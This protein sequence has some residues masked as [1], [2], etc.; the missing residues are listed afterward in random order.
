MALGQAGIER[1]GWLPEDSR[2]IGM[3]QIPGGTFR[4]GSNDHHEADAP[5]ARCIPENPRGGREADSYDPGQPNIQ[6][7]RKVLKGARLSA[8]LTIAAGIAPPHVPPNPSTHRRAMS[9]SDVSSERRRSHES[10]G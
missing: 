7:P 10:Q 2:N 4:I 8:R 9:V 1:N 3:V 5:K 6:I